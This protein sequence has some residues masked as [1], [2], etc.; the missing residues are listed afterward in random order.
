MKFNQ[1]ATRFIET[2]LVI[3]LAVVL[4]LGVL[5]GYSLAYSKTQATVSAPTRSVPTIETGL[6]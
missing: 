5:V 6:Q 1:K 2:E 3:I 4:L